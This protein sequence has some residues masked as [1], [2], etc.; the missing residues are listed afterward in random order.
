MIASGALLM[1]GLPGH[2]LDDSTRQLIKEEGVNNFIIFS[3]NV[4]NPGQLQNLCH[5]L[6]IECAAGHLPPPLIAID[7]EGGS[8]SRLPPPWTQFPDARLLAEAADPEQTLTDNAR[9][10]CR[11]LIAAGINLNMAPV[12]DVCPRNDGCFMERRALSGDP[13][14]V[15]RLGSLVIKAMQTTGVAACAKHFPG[16]GSAQLDPHLVLPTVRRERAQ[17]LA[18]DL[19][20]FRAAA[21][22]GVAAI[23]TSHT[24]YRALDP[25]QP[26]TLSKEILAGLLRRELGYQGL[27]ITD[28]LEMGAIENVLPVATAA[29]RSL[30]AGAD[31][32]LICR[33]HAKV[34]A[35]ISLLNEARQDGRLTDLQI[36]TAVKRINQVRERFPIRDSRF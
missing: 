27:V 3:R 21:A 31:L 5:D 15:A 12:L 19:L 18:E 28:D 4:K 26:A 2:D 20:P 29:L 14:T 17:L 36:E 16:L 30:T 22:A 8:V 6:A 1:I 10:C 23:M 13:A 25:E 7:Q 32:L 9:T 11:E 33:Q 35:T 34:R 24:I